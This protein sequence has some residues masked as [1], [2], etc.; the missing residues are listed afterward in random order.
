[1]IEGLKIDRAFIIQMNQ[2]EEKLSFVQ[3]ILNLTNGLGIY[4]IAEGVE[5]KEQY[6]FLEA[7]HS[8]I[9]QGYLCGR[10]LPYVEVYN[11]LQT[12]SDENDWCQQTAT[13]H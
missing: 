5:T 2:G 10:P 1:M 4:A 8:D 3:M 7:N 9:V 6:A 12:S 13:Q 11:L